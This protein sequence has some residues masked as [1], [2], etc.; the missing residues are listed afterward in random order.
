[1][2]SQEPREG[3]IIPELPIPLEDMSTGWK[4]VGE[5]GQEVYGG[6]LSYILTTY[7]YKRFTDV[8]VIVYCEY[9]VY[10][11]EYQVVDKESGYVI[12]RLGGTAEYS[13]RVRLLAKG[14]QLPEVRLMDEDD[15]GREPFLPT[16]QDTHYQEY[17]VKGRLRL[18]VEWSQKG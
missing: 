17:Q 13:C 1:M 11:A 9:P 5:V 3:R 7:A 8:P 12:L 14:R 16:S 10:Q 6:A 2:I 4:Q 15:L 18:R